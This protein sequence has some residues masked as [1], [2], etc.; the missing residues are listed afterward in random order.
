MKV[1]VILGHPR[2]D[3]YCAALAN[4]YI[5]CAENEYNN[6][7]IGVQGCMKC[8]LEFIKLIFIDPL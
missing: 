1:L 3:S 8:T 2:K 7:E 6:I 4:E 5:K